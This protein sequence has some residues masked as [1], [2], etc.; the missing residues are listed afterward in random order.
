MLAYYA[1]KLPTVEVNNTFYKMPSEKTLSDWLKKVGPDFIFTIKAPQRIT[2]R[3]RLK[4]SGESVAR[5][6]E[7]TAVLG[8]RRGPFLFQLPPFSKKNPEL[9]AEFLSGW[10]KDAPAAFE[11]RHPSWFSDDVYEVLRARGAALVIAESEKIT[12]PVVATADW[13]YLRLR[14]EEYVDA[15]IKAWA[16]KLRAQKWKQAFVYF[17]HEDAGTG[18]KLAARLRELLD[19]K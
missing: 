18:P 10:P 12:A 3:E 14:R 19:A 4:D 11:F 9:L 2:H 15:D 6:L 13:G 16:E 17:K 8:D 5:L 7:A 1:T